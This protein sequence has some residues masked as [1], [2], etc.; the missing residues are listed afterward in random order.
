VAE[1]TFPLSEN[2]G[3]TVTAGG[4]PDPAV[5]TLGAGIGHI[6]LHPVF[7]GGSTAGHE[8]VWAG[9]APGASIDEVFAYGDA[10]AGVLYRRRADEASIRI[11]V[12]TL[13]VAAPLAP[14]V[15]TQARGFSFSGPAV[16]IWIT[17]ARRSAG[18]CRA[19][20]DGAHRVVGGRGETIAVVSELPLADLLEVAGTVRAAT[21]EA[22]RD[23]MMEA[24][25]CG[26]PQ[27]SGATGRHRR[28]AAGRRSHLA[29]RARRIRH[30]GDAPD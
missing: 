8:L 20:T 27:W 26:P 12:S 17:G 6:G 4:R 15:L 3:V 22:W 29:W 21:P 5:I 16:G 24:R 9:A 10:R 7:G 30:L 28:G 11:T 2:V 25:G 23:A 1:L 18:S 14:F 19:S 13:D